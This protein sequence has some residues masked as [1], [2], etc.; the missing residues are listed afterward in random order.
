MQNVGDS[1]AA[2]AEWIDA[3]VLIEAPVFD[4]HE[5]SRHISRHFLQ[6]RRRA[7]E[8]AAA[9]KR[10]ALRVDDLDRGRTL[11]NFQRLDRRQMR[12]DP[13][14][15]TGAADREPQAGDQAPVCDAAD[16][17]ALA[18]SGACLACAPL[19]AA[20]RRL[21]VG[22]RPFRGR[23]RPVVGGHAQLGAFVK[24]RFPARARYVPA[25]TPSRDPFRAGG[26]NAPVPSGHAKRADL[27]GR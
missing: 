4:G 15:N 18:A 6:R 21:L 19:A 9:G 20:C 14:N 5:C 11:W 16:D 8:V 1:G 22:D 10:V 26:Y 27:R 12:A 17:C 25:L 2:D 3:I 23:C 13:G 7:G 24:G